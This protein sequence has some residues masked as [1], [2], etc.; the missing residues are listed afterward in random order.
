MGVFIIV[1]DLHSYN[2]ALF[3]KNRCSVLSFSQNNLAIKI[4]GLAHKYYL[5]GNKFIK[6]L[7][8]GNC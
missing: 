3:I 5:I 2:K 7:K 8:G 1:L 6:T 4:K